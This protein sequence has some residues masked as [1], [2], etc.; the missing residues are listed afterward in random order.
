MLAP[1]DGEGSGDVQNNPT[2]SGEYGGYYSIRGGYNDGTINAG[3]LAL[4]KAEM[5]QISSGSSNYGLHPGMSADADPNY[6]PAAT[7]Y[8]PLDWGAAKLY[9]D[10]NLGFVANVGSL[11]E[12]TT[13]TDYN[14]R[15][16]LPLGLYSHA[17]LQRH[18]QTGVPQ[19]RSHLTGWGG[20]M[21]DCFYAANQADPQTQ[22]ALSANIS[23]SG[24]NVFQN[25]TNVFP[26]TIGTGGATVL[27]YYRPDYATNSGR[28]HQDRIFSH[29]SDAF[30]AQDYSEDKL[31][32]AFAGLNKSARDAAIGFNAAVNGVTINTPFQ[33][34]DGLSNRLRKIAQVM[35]VSEASFG[36]KRQIF[37]VNE[38]GWDNHNNVLPAQINNLPKVSRGL[39]S[40]YKAMVELGLQD[41]FIL[42]TA[43]DFARTL[44]TNGQGSDHAWGGNQIVMGGSVDGGKIAGTYPN[45]ANLATLNT[46][47]GR[48]I[49][50]TSVDELA[51]E[52]ALW[53]GISN[54]PDLETVVPNIRTFY[55][56]AATTD[57]IGFTL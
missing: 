36:H 8:N 6:D 12:R 45:F 46:G 10:G 11:I 14:Q 33:T 28:N 42:F 2:V 30:S 54:G 9:Q 23:I 22:T 3:G 7:N 21:A 57:P 35:S 50:T 34:S 25:G 49:P 15:R 41:K 4:S 26:Y 27:N 53:F 16:N 44:T 31:A 52:L 56:A 1:F 18:W 24:V 17:D 32:E 51:A 29:L 19:S 47:R 20:R 37:F 38:G 13:L 39:S 5:T 55:D 40:F 48:L 43:S